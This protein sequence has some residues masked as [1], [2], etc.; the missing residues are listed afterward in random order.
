M[1]EKKTAAE[2]A[3]DALDAATRKF[4]R[5]QKRYEKADAEHLAAKELLAEAKSEREYAASHPALAGGAAQPKVVEEPVVA[6]EPEVVEEA[7]AEVV[8]TEPEVSVN[9]PAHAEQVADEP[10]IADDPFA[11]FSKSA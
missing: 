5:A 8:A 9:E 6:P 7:P 3:Q 2:K 4:E 11:E 1:A 10:K